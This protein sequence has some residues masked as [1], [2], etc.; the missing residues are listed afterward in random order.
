MDLLSE[1][2]SSLDIIGA[3][4]PTSLDQYTVLAVIFTV[5]FLGEYAIVAAVMVS[6]QGLLDLP[7][8]IIAS[9][10]GTLCADLFWFGVGR[11]FPAKTIP[12][13]IRKRLFSPVDQALSSLIRG[14][15]TTIVALFLLRFLMGA[16]LL[17]ILHLA[18]SHLTWLQFFLNNLIGTIFYLIILT[19]V[20]IQ[21][22][23]AADLVSPAYRIITS[24]LSGVFL[25]FI[26]SKIVQKGLAMTEIR[27]SSKKAGFSK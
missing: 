10:I 25:L 7:E 5:F 22:A 11:H 17:I 18:R 2:L 24:V 3:L 19:A 14:R 23:Q 4:L 21:L 13:G 16:R 8:V 9:L 6:Q 12:A 1:Q 15:K 20:G 26:L 27:R